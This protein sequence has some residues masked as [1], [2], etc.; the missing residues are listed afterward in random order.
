M[1]AVSSVLTVFILF[2]IFSPGLGEDIS[3]TASV[4]KNPV[5]IDEQFTYQVEVSGSIQNLPDVQLPDFKDIAILGGP[6]VSSSFQLN[7]FNMK[8]SKT[9]YVVLMG[10][11]TGTFRI[12]AATVKYKGKTYRSNTVEVTIEKQAGAGKAAPRSSAQPDHQAQFSDKELSKN[13]FLK[14][15]PSRRSA[16]VNQEITLRYKIYFRTNISNPEAV[17][18]PEAVGCWVE[19]YPIRKRP[20]VYTET[21]RG[22]QY[23]VAEI[24]KMAVFPSR[25]GKITISPL[26][27]MVETVV[28]SS[29]RDPFDFFNDPFGRVVKARV[30][31]DPV[32][33][34]ALSLPSRGKPDNFSG[35]VGDFRIHS[36]ID[37]ESV[38]TNEAVSLFV[39]ISGEGTLK[40]LNQLP[41]QFPPDFEVYDPKINESVNKSGGAITMN[42]EFEYVFIPRV[43]GEFRIKPFTVSYFNPEDKKYHDLRTPGYDVKVRRGK[44]IAASAGSGTALSKE[45]VKLLGSDIRFIKEDI[46]GFHSID[47]LPYERWWF[48]ALLT[49]PVVFLGIA[50]M[51]RNHSEKMSTNVQYARSR[52]ARKQAQQRLKEANS[53]LKQGRIADF[54]SAISRGLVG[55]LADKTNQSAAGLVR[56]NV[57]E[58]LQQHRVGEEM[59][60]EFL[61]C[62]DEADFRRFAPGQVVD[63]E[64]EASYQNAEK[65]LIQLEKYF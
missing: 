58:L 53:Y 54:Y 51:Y 33:I 26:E 56:D 57:V 49:L 52:K 11:E 34:N 12:G 37:K 9:Y 28:R 8:A 6:N 1:K 14:V 64:M 50:W 60:S 22:V 7:N 29:S 13:V 48:Y 2:S 32:E 35:L 19:E 44:E 40:F 27:L 36:S 59:Q 15:F 42:K 24:K 45:E 65:I 20:R 23:N 31:S 30:R 47:T 62:L 46:S 5:G 10:K 63:S 25:P 21:V 3:I 43:P 17:K 55:Y 41:V 16:Y 4:D 38:Q 39:K 18:I 61:K